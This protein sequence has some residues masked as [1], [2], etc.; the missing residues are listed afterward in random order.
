MASAAIVL[1][2]TMRS[3][4]HLRLVGLCGA[5]LFVTYGV[6]AEAWPVVVTNCVTSAV[7]VSRLRAAGPGN[8]AGPSRSQALPAMSRNTATVP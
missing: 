7:H 3:M 6:L 8:Q 2:L 5:V 4:T 1:S